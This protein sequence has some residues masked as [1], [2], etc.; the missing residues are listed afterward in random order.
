MH[1]VRQTIHQNVPETI[2]FFFGRF[3]PLH[4]LY[5]C[6]TPIVTQGFRPSYLDE[7]V[8]LSE[9]RAKTDEQLQGIVNSKLELGLNFVV[10]GEVE[11]S[12]GDRAKA[13]RSLKQADQAL[14]EVQRLFPAL[15]DEQ[16]RLVA[17][18]L[19]DLREAVDRLGHI[20]GCSRTQTASMS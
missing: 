6:E 4:R 3:P 20:R 12:A 17:R 9:L 18:K 10:L 16:R 11:E 5:L 13:E 2:G 14:S 19:D 8:K 7:S 15:N 1:E